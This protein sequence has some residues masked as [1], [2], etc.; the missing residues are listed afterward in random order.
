MALVRATCWRVVQGPHQS[1]FA[2]VR[3]EDTTHISTITFPDAWRREDEWYRFRTNPRENVQVLVVVNDQDLGEVTMNGDHPISWMHEF[4][5]G[6]S[7]YTGMGHTKES[8]WKRIFKI[9]S[10]AELCGPWG[11]ALN[12]KIHKR[13][14][15]SI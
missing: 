2:T 6:R 7:W 11:R 10:G 13:V 15:H 3:R 9:T 4:E 12:Q 1:Y 5:G 14:R 8:F